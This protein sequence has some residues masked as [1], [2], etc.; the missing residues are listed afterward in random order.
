MLKKGT[1]LPKVKPKKF[2]SKLF[3]KLAKKV[4]KVKSKVGRGGR[5]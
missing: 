4:A 2:N 1:K 3:V 5:D